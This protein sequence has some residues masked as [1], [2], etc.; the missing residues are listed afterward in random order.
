MRVPL[1]FVEE[2][3][4]YI[5]PEASKEAGRMA[6]W[7]SNFGV[8]CYMRRSGPVCRCPSSFDGL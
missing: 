5:G 3:E 7:M 1:Y 8:V 6:P 2:I 4:V